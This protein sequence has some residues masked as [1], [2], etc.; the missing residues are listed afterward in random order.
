MYENN[1]STADDT[2]L[3][4]DVDRYEYHRKNMLASVEN[5]VLDTSHSFAMEDEVNG[6]ESVQML[7]DHWHKVA[8]TTENFRR[9][10]IDYV[11]PAL[12]RVKDS[13]INEDA[14]VADQLNTE[15]EIDINDVVHKGLEN[16]RNGLKKATMALVDLFDSDMD[17][18]VRAILNKDAYLWT[19][20]E[21]YLVSMCYVKAVRMHNIEE[22]N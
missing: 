2:S 14:E 18:N 4:L 20:E 15:A 9:F 12:V 16:I 8:E 11:D 17:E 7:I 10:Y 22:L 21:A 1:F 13:I 3:Y 6:T 19:K 5:L